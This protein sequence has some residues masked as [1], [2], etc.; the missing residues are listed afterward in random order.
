MLQNKLST[1]NVAVILMTDDARMIHL[2]IAN[3][4]LVNVS[5]P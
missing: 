1:A 2:F 3:I 5:A 4:N